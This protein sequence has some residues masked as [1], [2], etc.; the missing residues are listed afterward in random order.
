[1]KIKSIEQSKGFA[2]I[3]IIVVLVVICLI[4]FS[5]LYI[6]SKHK[7]SMNT[8]GKLYTTTDAGLFLQYDT[9]TAPAGEQTYLKVA[10]GDSSDLSGCG[11]IN[12]NFQGN[13]AITYAD[14]NSARV[15][16]TQNLNPK[17]PQQATSLGPSSENCADDL[18][19]PEY[20]TNAEISSNWLN[21]GSST[22][23][24]VINGNDF[25]ITRNTADYSLTLGNST[26]NQSVLRRIQPDITEIGPSGEN[27]SIT[28][29]S[30]L[31]SYLRGAGVELADQKY[32]GIT[33][34][35]ATLYPGDT[36]EGIYALVIKGQNVDSLTSTTAISPTTGCWLQLVTNPYWSDGV[37][38]SL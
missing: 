21:G 22:K 6:Y 19:P 27:C 31:D 37:G 20:T 9:D 11:S 32:P 17:A 23:S 36:N 38:I 14:A 10:F 18:G 3:E 4:V 34:K 26:T 29:T 13:I 28:T 15:T 5:G 8:A 30:Q 7:N 1:M 12:P 16:I 33:Q 2:A 24:F 35:L 25:T